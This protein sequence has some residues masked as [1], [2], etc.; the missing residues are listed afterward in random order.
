MISILHI[1]DLHFSRDAAMHNMRKVLLDEAR[2]KTHDKPKGEK[3][4][5][6]TGDF[7]NFW[8][9]DYSDAIKFMRD[10]IESMDIEPDKDIFIIPGNHDVSNDKVLEPIIKD[11]IPE[12]KK[13][14]SAALKMISSGD[15]S[16]HDWRM[17][18]FIPY[19]DFAREIDVYPPADDHINDT[20]P[21]QV[22]IRRWRDKLNILH[23]NTA[24]IADGN[25]KENQM[26]DITTATSPELWEKWYR[27]DIPA[28]ALG[29]NSFYDLEKRQRTALKTM[30][31]QYNISAYLCG[32]THL[33]ELDDEKQNIPIKAG[34]KRE[35]IP[36]VVCAKSVAHMSD[37]YSDFGFY[38]HEWNDKSDEVTVRFYK[39]VESYFAEI[40]PYGLDFTYPMRRKAPAKRPEPICEEK[41]TQKTEQ[42]DRK[43]NRA[44]CDY[45]AEV[46]KQKRDS[47]PSF[48]LL[49]ADEI[50]NRLF[51][52]VEEYP[53]IP[54][55]AKIS[56]EEKNGICPVWD[57]IK[58]SWSSQNRRSVV[59]IGEGGIGK[60][61]ALFSITNQ[62]EEKTIPTIY[63]P[64]YEL[65]E[66]DERL[67]DLS[68]HIKAKYTRYGD[69]IEKL[70]TEPWDDKP[71]LLILLDGFNEVPNSLR[72]PLLG[73][74][75]DWHDSHPGVQIVA[76]S[77]PMDGLNLSMELAGNPIPVT[78][79]VLEKASVRDYLKEA[80]RKVPV[81][82]SPLWGDFRYP[83]FLILYIKTGRLKG[84]TAA[85]YPLMIKDSDN[86][87]ALIWN[88]LQRELLRHSRDRSQKAEEWVLRCAVA[89]EFILPEIAYRMLTDQRM[90]VSYDQVLNW[91]KESLARLDKT[92]LPKHL[93]SIWEKYRRQHGG[94]YP[95]KELFNDQI[96]LDTV[97]QD[98]GLLV[99]TYR[100]HDEKTE[101]PDAGNFVFMHQNF[102]DCLAGLYLVNQAEM[103]SEELFPTVWGTLQSDLALNYASELVDSEVIDKLWNANRISQQYK[104]AEYRKNHTA[105][106]NLLEIYSR[107]KRLAKELDFSGVDIHDLSLTKYLGK[108]RTPLPLFRNAAHSDATALDRATFQSNGHTESISVLAVLQDGRVVSG[109]DDNTLRVWDAASGQCLQTLEGHSSGVTCV[110]VLQDGRVVSGSHDGTLH[111]W[112]AASGQCLQALEGH[113]D[114][115]TCVAVLQGGRV[116]SGSFDG[117][118]RVWDAASGQCLQAVEGHS[119]LVSCVAVLPDGRV[120]SG[121]FDGTL[122]VWDAASGQCLQ[123]LEG[124]SD[125]VT[126]VAVLQ[127]GR[128]VSGS[129]DGTPRVWDAASGQCLQTLEGHSDLVS[130]VAVLP[131]SRV[132]SGSH[133]GTLRVWDATSGQCLQTLEGHS[134]RVSCVAVLPDGRVVSDSFDG[135][136]RVWDAASGQCLQT[137]EGHSSRVSCV[138]VLPDGR[139]VSG[140]FDGTLRVWDAASLKCIDSL[141][142][143]EVDVS[144]MNFSR[145]TL[146]PDLAILL[147]RN[148]AIISSSDYER[149][150]FPNIRKY[151]ESEKGKTST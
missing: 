38:W 76:V 80:G 66:K 91:T 46:L 138:A 126:C 30:F 150:V 137:L 67:I 114:L 149:Y 128:V 65:V 55:K 34:N 82:T 54:S 15:L 63:I 87:G 56:K 36:N 105:T 133:D 53:I 68:A 73:E 5:I 101:Q 2:K 104:N 122:R 45:L 113:S 32:D 83:L 59:I 17:E 12:W 19:C 1:S 37:A 44:L 116:V 109:S 8:D 77:R 131:D 6:V 98:T 40:G 141:E 50:D 47:H 61:V 111:V 135:T 132:V 147:W 71:N 49:K 97:L 79:A 58:D 102:R 28:L 115:V 3:L 69:E 139:V 10:L 148:R 78:L 134:S 57:V 92:A 29:H 88:Y 145:A 62:S 99:S 18:M 123:T 7:H 81:D 143:M 120:V 103:S 142:A 21:A 106:Y 86:R 20:T 112:D 108:N 117:T 95:K 107:N 31:A 140:S 96:W 118:L 125:L 4:L 130:C 33:V 35:F 52:R 136:L 110:A 124:H 13:H 24:L 146:T 9:T 26:A 72:R 89:N 60:T 85:G 22:H 127:D 48:Q 119:D 11:V 75:N 43:P 16:F 121:S 93:N 90:D 94:C 41:P 42:N 39:W 51:P 151:S 74:I 64:M 27:E 25:A 100:T 84:K 144:Q 14:K 129:F 70:A 23:L